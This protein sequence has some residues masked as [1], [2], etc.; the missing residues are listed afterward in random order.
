METF[1][2][3]EMLYFLVSGLTAIGLTLN[4][5]IPKSKE[6]YTPLP[7]KYLYIQGAA[8]IAIAVWAALVL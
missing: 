8:Y 2:I 5:F 3:V 1:I 4:G 6:E 7:K